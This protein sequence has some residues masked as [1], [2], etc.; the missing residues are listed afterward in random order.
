M[1]T[2]EKTC[3]NFENCI[4]A[5]LYFI[6]FEPEKTIHFISWRCDKGASRILR[7]RFLA[8]CLWS[9][10]GRHHGFFWQGPC[11]F[12][13]RW[14]CWRECSTGLNLRRCRRGKPLN[15]LGGQSKRELGNG[16]HYRSRHRWFWRVFRKELLGVTCLLLFDTFWFL[17]EQQYLAWISSFSFHRRLSFPW[18]LLRLVRSS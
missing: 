12:S 16:D 18:C 10:D 6:S 7:Y 11:L 5:Y 13:L 15:F 1:V 17:W 3:M 2:N 8:W 4:Y 14:L 9:R